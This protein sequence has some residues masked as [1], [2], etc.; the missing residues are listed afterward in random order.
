[1]NFVDGNNNAGAAVGAYTASGGKNQQW[2][3]ALVAGGKQTNC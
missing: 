1:M 3:F 2:K